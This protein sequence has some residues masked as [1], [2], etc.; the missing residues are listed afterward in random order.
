M[1]QP[2]AEIYLKTMNT[3]KRILDLGGFRLDKRT[4]E[5][6]YFKEE[7]MNYTYENLKKLFQQMEE[8]GLIQKCECNT[9]LRKGYKNCICKGSGYTNK[10]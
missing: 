7:V 4:K 3:M 8:N 6:K 9:N 5:F 2:P 10:K 1:I